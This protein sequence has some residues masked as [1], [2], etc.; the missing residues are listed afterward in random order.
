[1]RSKIVDLRRKKAGS[2]VPL[3]LVPFSGKRRSP[4]RWRRRRTRALIA[5]VALTVLAAAGFGLSWLSYSPQFTI[6]S[7]AVTG[8]KAVPTNLIV[9]FVETKLY[10]G[11]FT[12]LS[13]SNIFLYPR[14]AIE[15]ELADFFPRIRTAAITRESLLATAITVMVAE[16]EPYA[17]WCEGQTC[18]LL[19]DEGF[20]FA[21]ATS[22]QPATA[23]IYRGDLE[24]GV[25]PI[26]KTFL[27]GRFAGVEA[28][29]Q[30]LGQ[31]GFEVREVSAESDKDFLLTLAK[32]YALKVSYGSDS[33]GLV[34]NLE[35]V[36]SS[37]TLRGKENELEYVDL[38]FGNRVYYK[39][40]GG[41]E[42][43]SE[44]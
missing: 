5:L 22:T 35:L 34:G 40:K 21:S 31:A 37:P 41:E 9:R 32:G 4:L 36:L 12:A 11:A 28:L 3:P 38:R 26:G 7:I 10:S 23:Q 20:I 30:R 8:A 19:D 33:P 1:M 18:Y 27:S 14:R 25:P 2:H 42:Q 15:E 13:R 16:R 17:R 43:E 44:E 39:L 6:Q 24:A 29:V